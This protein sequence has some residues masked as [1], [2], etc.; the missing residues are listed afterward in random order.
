M[1]STVRID[2]GH[3]G[4]KKRFGAVSPEALEEGLNWITPFIDSVYHMHRA[5]FAD[6]GCRNKSNLKVL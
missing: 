2:A 4:I 1:L 6:M 5:L 3:V